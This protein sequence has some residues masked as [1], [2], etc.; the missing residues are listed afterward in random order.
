MPW[1]W[2]AFA[3]AALAALVLASVLRSLYV[4]WLWYDS[5]GFL[6]VYRRMLI[7]RVSLFVG[8]FLLSVAVMGVNV[9]LAYR[10]APRAREVSFLPEVDVALIRQIV[11]VTL[12]IA[13]L[14]LALI[15]G[16]VA[17]AGWQTVALWL[18]GRSFGIDDPQFGR[19]LSFYTF[20][21]PA[22]QWLRGWILGV[23]G[24]GALAATGVY[25]LTLTLQGT[26][27]ITRGMRLHGSALAALVVLALAAGSYL[28]IFDLLNA[29]DGIVYGATYADIHAR[30]PVL[31]VLAIFGAFAA[32]AVVAH[33]FLATGFRLPLA[34]VGLSALFAVIGGVVYPQLV[35]TFR[36][37]P[38]E[39]D[40]E[41]AYI[42][43]NI[44]FTRA[45]WGL[46]RIEES[47]FPAAPTVTAEEVD[48]NRPTVDNIRL[49]DPRPLRDTMNQVQSIRPLYYFHD[50][51]VDRYELGG[52]IRQ[53]MISARELD[54][55]RTEN[56]N[57]TREHLQLTHG[58]GA[59]ITPA[60]DVAT[61]EGL[62]LLLTSDIP[63][64]GDEIPIT[65]DGARIYFGELTDHY[66]IVNS[67][68][69]EFDYPSG[70]VFAETRYAEDRGIRLSSP[71]RRL[72]LAWE[73][74]DLN[75]LISDRIHAESRILMRRAVQ[76]RIATVAPFL[77]L[78]ADP[79][80]L[81]HDGEL[82][83]I[84]DAY[85][86]SA[87]YP[88][89]QPRDGINYI[90]NSVKILL[91]ARTGDM[92]FFL[93]DAQDPVARTWARFLPGLFESDSAMPDF[94][95]SHLRYPSGIFGLQAD[96]YRR[97]HIIEP[98]VFF[99]GEDIWDIP[100]E[101]LHR[102]EQPIE[103]YYVVMVLP[104][105]EQEEFVLMRPFTPRNKQNAVAWMAGRSDG[106]HHGQLRAF[107]F[108]TDMLVFGPAQIEARIDQDPVIS[109]Q[110]SLWDQLGSEV[111]RGNLLM[112]P[113]GRSFLFV[114]PVYLQSDA[115]RLPELKRVIVATGSRIAMEPSFEQA[116][117]VVL[118]RAAPSMPVTPVPMDGMLPADAAPLLE[119]ARTL[120]E[121]L[122]GLLDELR[123]L[124][125]QRDAR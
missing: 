87:R 82:H 47:P 91:H 105:E 120:L 78:D 25:A 108:P 113:I 46:D 24:A 99:A 98:A 29:A 84:Q 26:G 51:D 58:F 11:A 6:D 102:Q 9:A 44:A 43:R 101:K 122:A 54:I 88:Y 114:E 34:L 55:E 27:A 69:Q 83:W 89:S 86:T 96:L 125:E 60:H 16:A 77:R 95:R 10:L 1:R 90:R 80:L 64:R 75:L 70:P 49:L 53:V 97:Y 118:D 124:S 4:D 50:I 61:E 104:G 32:L 38:N 106:E 57:W 15:F 37:Q 36:V 14:L 19:D 22:L 8:G 68:E 45:A 21:L 7:V 3:A 67:D 81:V 85:T 76:Q 59:V 111:I 71:F 72:L 65:V 5:V 112:I 93:I 52:R 35:Q 116:L 28:R 94:M 121:R 110:L 79:Y 56:V 20:T 73:F 13:V 63:P 31:T 33:G 12:A 30:V 42:E 17:A 92:R 23:L 123:Q 18:N 48:A 107:R 109:P 100:M 103:P 117:D 40:R 66:V 115:S 74:G 39:L 62:P 119:E 41:R 2:V